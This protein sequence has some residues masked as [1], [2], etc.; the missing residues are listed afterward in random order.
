MTT[1][2]VLLCDDCHA[3]LPCKNFFTNLFELID[4]V[5]NLVLPISVIT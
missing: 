3:I 4:F 5:L 1:I 2:V